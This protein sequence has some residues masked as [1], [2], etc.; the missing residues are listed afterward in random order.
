MAPHV[1]QP[2]LTACENPGGFAEATSASG[3]VYL[4]RADADVRGVVRFKSQYIISGHP[5][6][7]GR[8]SLVPLDAAVLRTATAA[9]NEIFVRWP[10]D[11]EIELHT[12]LLALKAVGF[13]REDFWP[14]LAFPSVT[15]DE[16]IIRASRAIPETATSDPFV[17]AY[18][19][20]R[21]RCNVDEVRRSLVASLQAEIEDVA[22]R[23]TLESGF[24]ARYRVERIM[25]VGSTSRGTYAAFPSDFDLVVHT[26]RERTSMDMSEVKHAC[27][28][29]VEGVVQSEAFERYWQ[30]ILLS[31]CRPNLGPPFVELEGLGPR[32]PQSLVARYDLVWPGS[33]T[34]DRYGFL[35]VTF[36]KL[37][38][39]IGYEISIRRFF[40][41]LGPVWAE[42]V[43]AEICIAKSVLRALGEVYG[44]ANRGLRAHAVEQWIIQS[45]GYRSSGLPVGTLN[46]ALRL[47]V[48]ESV[49]A[50]SS[51]SM[52]PGSFEAFKERFPL[53]HPGWWEGDMGF[54][55]GVRNVNLWDLLG[56]GNVTE[57]EHKWWKLVALGLAFDRIQS[58]AETWKIEGLV[59]SAKLTLGLIKAGQPILPRA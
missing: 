12:V 43:R 13:H 6:D 27:D 52:A 26:E 5:G 53:W 24:A 38:Q 55:P 59:D 31:A 1:E 50:G 21:Q 51:G 2:D 34:A 39:I 3:P 35:D 57:A 54:V 48:E 41:N 11:R 28:N 4:W 25:N 9:A 20:E 42:R 8:P 40:E 47:I 17:R 49:A 15:E 58:N 23:V 22:A 19:E 37:P 30:A 7:D 33:G 46:N 45:F 44:S 32:G 14:V 29:L 36:G 56:D 10:R 16:L 18:A